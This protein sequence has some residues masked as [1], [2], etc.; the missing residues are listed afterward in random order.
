MFYKKAQLKTKSTS[1]TETDYHDVLKKKR[2]I[3]SSL[4]LKTSTPMTY[5]HSIRDSRL[6]VT[7]A[8][9]VGMLPLFSVELSVFSS[10]LVLTKLN[11]A[12]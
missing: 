8:E 2:Q 10:S 1:C 3:M 11:I 9:P 12:L 7:F 4:D 6:S 5:L